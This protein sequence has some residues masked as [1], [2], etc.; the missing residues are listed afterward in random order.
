MVK[1]GVTCGRKVVVFFGMTA[2]GK[3]TIARAYAEKLR[4]PWYNTD[5]ERKVLAGLAPTDP[6]PDD[7][8]K[9]IYSAELTAQTYGVL[10]RKAGEELASGAEQVVLDGSYAKRSDRDDVAAM[11]KE[12][13]ATVVFVYCTC[14]E[15]E[16]GRRFRLRSDDPRSVSDGR[17]EIYRYQQK[18][19]E[20]PR[21]DEEGR[22]LILDTEQ[23]L[24]ELV[25][26][27]EQLL[28]NH[29]RG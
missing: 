16:T 2:A 19:F 20:L 15:E 13:G 3:S 25:R 11:A 8:G 6:R 14:S 28:E 10:L 23:D 4:V 21:E 7:V 26:Q 12:Q 27:V 17:W 5:R 29:R 1:Q 9:G 24:S 22:V 18:T